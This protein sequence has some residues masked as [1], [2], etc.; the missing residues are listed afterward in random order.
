MQNLLF[1]TICI[2]GFFFI[3]YFKKKNIYTLEHLTDECTRSIDNFTNKSGSLFKEQKL[4]Q[5]FSIASAS[6]KA[7]EMASF[8]CV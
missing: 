4:L 2:D 1:C 6:R 3:S 7:S 8:S 5:C